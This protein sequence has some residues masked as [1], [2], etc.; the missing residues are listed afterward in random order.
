MSRIT[1]IG[2][3]GYAGS[4]ITAEAAARGHRVTALSRSRPDA[5]IPNVT[6]VQGDASDEAA[7]SA[8]I[9]NADVVVG[10][11]APRGPLADTFRDVYRT[12]ARLVD[13]AGVPLFIVGGAS[14]L[15]PAPGADRFVA[16]L[17]HIPAELHGEIRAGAALVIEDLPATPASLDWVFVSPALRFGA[18]M[19]GERLGRY[20]L[21][22]EAAVQP[23]DGGA[24]SAADY[25]LGFL[26]LIDKGEHHRAQVNLGH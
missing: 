18:R 21:G 1:V 13:A 5:P 3:T 25:A 14:S 26:D 7:L 9:E 22:G 15:R 12:I 23:E 6:Y 11:L 2:G 16:D 19:P 20:R 4:A 24:I 17:S 10:A 8:P